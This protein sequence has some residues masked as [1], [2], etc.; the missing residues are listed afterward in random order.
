[1]AA[2]NGVAIAMFDHSVIVVGSYAAAL[3][4]TV[5]I[6]AAM[7][8]MGYGSRRRSNVSRWLPVIP[9]NLLILAYGLSP[10]WRSRGSGR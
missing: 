4:N 5:P 6:G 9:F 10:T 1:M 7:L 2:S 3:I 8:L